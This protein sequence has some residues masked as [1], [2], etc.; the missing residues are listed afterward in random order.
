M[1]DTASIFH[2]G[3]I[4]PELVSACLEQYAAEK[5]TGAYSCFLGQVRADVVNGE[6]VIA[7]EYT[8]YTSM[9]DDAFLKINAEV[10][11]SFGLNA[12]FIK[13]SIGMVEAGQIC[14]LVL[15]MAAHR[16]AA[17]DACN[18]LVERIKKELPIWGKEVVMG[19]GYQWKEN[20]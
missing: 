3:P 4:P 14:L 2:D 13:H 5:T 15:T 6:E 11:S 9:A 17:M 19:E 16:K 8:A 1:N 10:T 18:I 7:I 20:K 12:S